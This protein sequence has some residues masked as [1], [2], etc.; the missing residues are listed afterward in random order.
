V[1]EILTGNLPVFRVAAAIDHF[2]DQL[3]CTGFGNG[4]VNDVDL[5]SRGDEGFLH[6]V[7]LVV[8][9]MWKWKRLSVVKE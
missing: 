5:G 3:V 4:G 9:M 8:I 1:H 2:D 6:I 7:W